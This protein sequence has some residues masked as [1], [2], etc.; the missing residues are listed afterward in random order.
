MPKGHYDR[1]ASA[2]KPTPRREYPA[3]LVDRADVERLA[4][5]AAVGVLAWRREAHLDRT[6]LGVEQDGARLERQYRVAVL[7][8]R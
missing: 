6:R 4:A 8:D 1:A 5:D 2:W 3:A 7:I